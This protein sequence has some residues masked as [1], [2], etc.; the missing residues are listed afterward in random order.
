MGRTEM[1]KVTYAVASGFPLLPLRIDPATDCVATLA[2]ALAELD[3][4]R[5]YYADLGWVRRAVDAQAFIAYPTA[6]NSRDVPVLVEIVTI[7]QEA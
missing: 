3:A 7:E 5:D 2:D 1:P 4:A 6:D